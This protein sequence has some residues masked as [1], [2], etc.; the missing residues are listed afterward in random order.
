MRYDLK[1]I[2]ELAE[3][4]IYSLR[5]GER[6]D[7]LEHIGT[8]LYRVFDRLDEL[9]Q[10]DSALMVGVNHTQR[11]N[12]TA[13]KKNAAAAKSFFFDIDGLLPLSS[14]NASADPE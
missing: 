8:T 7:S 12:T 9:S 5:K 6:G 13:V 1:E 3:K 4:K 11:F 10:A 14:H 2:L